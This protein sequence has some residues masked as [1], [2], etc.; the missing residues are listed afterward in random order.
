MNSQ[1]FSSIFPLE[2]SL[3]S[4]IHILLEFQRPA[5]SSLLAT[6][7][8]GERRDIYTMAAVASSKFLT[9]STRPFP[10]CPLTFPW[11]GAAASIRWPRWRPV[12]FSLT[13]LGRFRPAPSRLRGWA[14]RHLCD[15]RDGV[16]QEVLARCRKSQCFDSFSAPRSN[17]PRKACQPEVLVGVGGGDTLFAPN[18][19]AL[20]ACRG[21]LSMRQTADQS[22]LR[23]VLT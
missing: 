23:A 6:P 12:S 2:S 4:T 13:R 8:G 21:P 11:V 20:I 15:G 7:V 19:E 5:L 14:P 18:D 22:G 10:A 3:D 1:S 17:L 16:K 9:Y